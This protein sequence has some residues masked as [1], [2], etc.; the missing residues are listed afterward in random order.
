MLVEKTRKLTDWRYV[1]LGIV[2]LVILGAALVGQG[3]ISAQAGGRGYGKA[4]HATAPNANGQI[5]ADAIIRGHV[6]LM[7]RPTPP[8]P[9]WS[10]PVSVSLQSS[11][12]DYTLE[13]ASITDQ[14]GYF[15]IT[16]ELAPGVYAWRA[17]NPQTLANAGTTTV[18]SGTNTIE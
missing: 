5:P 7:G 8:E 16:S 12:G 14:S 11:L 17:K 2:L 10:V 3:T 13:Q 18:A 6:L 15:T 9:R 1:S 4:L